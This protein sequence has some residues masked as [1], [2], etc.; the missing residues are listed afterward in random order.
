MILSLKFRSSFNR[1]LSI[2]AASICLAGTSS[3]T[4]VSISHNFNSLGEI[5]NFDYQ[6]Q[7]SSTVGFDMTGGVGGSGA[8]VFQSTGAS[9]LDKRTFGVYSPGTTNTDS[10]TL[11]TPTFALDAT[12]TSSFRASIMVHG[13]AIGDTELDGKRKA[14]VR[15]GFLGSLNIPDPTKP[16]DIWKQNAS[17]V[18]DAKIEFENSAGKF[19]KLSIEPKASPGSNAEVKAPKVEIQND[20]VGAEFDVDNWFR[21]DLVITRYTGEGAGPQSFT[22]GGELLDLGPD[23]TDEPLSL[24]AVT[25]F[26]AFNLVPY[27]NLVSF[28]T[29]STI[30][31]AY[32]LEIEKAASP[33]Q[34]GF[35]VDNMTFEA[36]PEANSLVLALVGSMLL[37]RRRRAGRS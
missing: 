24:G 4:I 3:A 17:F 28:G 34:Y 35:Q 36:V 23:G 18:M 37:G 9:G 10:T 14:Q 19:A 16:Q 11:D 25:Y 32:Q 8:A 13:S 22:F 2:G 7:N 12:T 5:G 1:M 6:N 21:F 26:D 20:G 27:L 30:F 33:G 15:F 29:D 31:F